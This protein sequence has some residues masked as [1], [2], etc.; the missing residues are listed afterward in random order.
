MG[1]VLSIRQEAEADLAEAYQ[2][3]EVCR[4]GLGADFLLCV[5]EALEKITRNP[6]RYKII[7]KNCSRIFVHRFPYGVYFVIREDRVIVLAVMHARKHPTNWK[8]RT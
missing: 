4:N 1:F 7:H 5:E 8:I 3:Y 6:R 2:Y